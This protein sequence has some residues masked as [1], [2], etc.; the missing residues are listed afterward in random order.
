M[1]VYL[2]NKSFFTFRGTESGALS[3]LGKTVAELM[4]ER[5]N[6]S[7]FAEDAGDKVVLYPVYPF[8]NGEKLSAYLSRHAGSFRFR[9]GYVERGGRAER[10]VEEEPDEGMYT[11]GDYAR[12][13]D[14]AARENAAYHNARGALVEEG[15]EVGFGVKLGKGTAVRR[16]AR[17]VGDCEIGENCEIGGGCEIEN[18]AV[19]RGTSVR[20]SVLVGARVG[21]NCAVG[22]NAYLRQGSAVGDHCRIGDFVEIKNS[23]VGDGCKIS[24]LAY[25]GDADLGERVNVGCGAV[26]VNYNGKIK[27]RSRVG[28]GA[29]IGSNCNLVAPVEVGDGAFLAAGTT[30][31]EDLASNDFAVGRCRITVKGGR[32]RKYLQ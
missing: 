3:V 8:L 12:A 29:F 32:A 13:L 14:R 6:A 10:E 17:L 31:A 22:P 24:H 27:Q 23:V 18:S 5:L 7:G 16:G 15:A 2:K 28:N 26:F 4:T 19:G 21:R 11:L 30:L 25:V 1:K 20:C 9:G